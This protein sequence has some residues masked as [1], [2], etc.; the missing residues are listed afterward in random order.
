M[1]K[2]ELMKRNIQKG[3]LAEDLAKEELTEEGWEVV[4][5]FIPQK[6]QQDNG[7]FKY[8]SKMQISEIFI[9]TGDWTLIKALCDLNDSGARLPDFV[10]KK[11]N[12]VKL[13]EVKNTNAK[14]NPIINPIQQQKAIEELWKLGYATELINY[15][16]DAYS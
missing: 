13:V 3:L 11:G 6:Q 10:C 15:H 7:E 14:L 1:D 12:E 9:L 8:L 2:S 4:K 16:T 5:I